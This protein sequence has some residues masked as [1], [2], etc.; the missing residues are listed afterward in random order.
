MIYTMSCKGILRN[1][2]CFLH[3]T[4]IQNKKKTKFHLMEEKRCPFTR[5]FK[6]TDKT[7]EQKQHEEIVSTG[8]YL[9]FS[10]ISCK[11]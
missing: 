9:K 5:F 4:Y 6:V 1:I 10:I 8:A 7:K 3:R 2:N 11:Y